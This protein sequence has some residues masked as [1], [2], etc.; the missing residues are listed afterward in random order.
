MSNNNNN[1]NNANR[2]TFDN[3][4]NNNNNNRGNRSAG[5]KSLQA[6]QSMSGGNQKYGSS[7]NSNNNDRHRH[8]SMQFM[9][10]QNNN[11]NINNNEFS[12]KPSLPRKTSAPA[13][14]MQYSEAFIQ[15]RSLIND[16]DK[17]NS[18]FKS[19]LTGYQHKEVTIE[20][21]IDR[22]RKY[23]ISKEAL[24]TIYNWAFDQHDNERLLLT[25]IICECVSRNVVMT[26]DLL[27]ALKDTLEL[28]QDLACDLPLV[29]N[30]IGQLLALPL[31]K[32]ILQFKDLL[33]ISKSQIEEFGNGETIL[34]NIMKVIE[35]NHGK[36]AL[37]Q[38][39]DANIDFRM[40]LNKESNLDDFLK[41]NVSIRTNI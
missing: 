15:E 13:R 20:E 22:L 17:V 6:S 32:R 39:N 41:E 8:P 40:F 4:N 23:R 1:N 25:E 10:R 37:V 33:N 35:Q 18:I 11:N 3:R 36:N 19:S 16:P 38:L 2:N 26:K 14:P 24:V 21:I 30:Y 5:S 27:D 31:V 9:Q 28:A 34:K 7:R 12:T 29:Y